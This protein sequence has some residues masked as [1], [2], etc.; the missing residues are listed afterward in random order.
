MH[1]ELS[2]LLLYSGVLRGGGTSLARLGDI[3]R[4]FEG[5]ETG[6][7]LLREVHAQSL[8]LIGL[9]TR[10]GFEGDLWQNYLT[11]LLLTDENPFSL[12][13]EGPSGDL[14]DGESVP[15]GSLDVLARQDLEVFRGLFAFDFGPLER[16]LGTGGLSILRSFKAGRTGRPHPAGPLV[17]DMSEKIAHSKSAG[18]ALSLLKNFYRAHGVGALAFHRAFHV[19][20]ELALEPIEA[21][22]PAS[23]DAL[24]GYEVQK[25]EL[26]ANTEAFLAGRPANNVLLYGDGGTGKSTSVRALVND[27]FNS[28]LRMVELYRQ[29]F[30]ALPSILAVLRRR[31]YRFILFIDDLSFEEHETEYKALKAAVEGGLE[32][33][34]ENVLIYATSNRRHLIRETWGD[35]DDMERSGD[36]HRS[37]TVEEKLSLASRFGLALNYSAPNRKEYHEIVC[38]LARSASLPVSDAL[39]KGADAW[40]IRHGGV[41]GR[42]A[43]QYIDHLAGRG[44]DL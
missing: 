2:K 18:E 14:P 7:A 3:L 16:A 44:H 29:Q 19:N 27:Y 42:T 6:D 4:R 39:T 9:A 43:R 17:R 35:R 25:R 41:S 22:E 31:S 23:L 13:C 21:V 36:I 40:E 5:G 37:D 20:G 33:R 26:R 30:A 24:A 28:G 12:G 10:Y 11:W 8:C 1:R 32:A 15:G 34:P 38:A